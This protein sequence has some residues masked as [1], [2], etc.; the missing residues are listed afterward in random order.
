MKRDL[1]TFEKDEFDLL[2]IGGGIAGACIARDAAMRGLNVGLIE[3]N[4]FI[5]ATSAAPSKLIHGG[6]RYLKNFEL[7]LVRE[8]LAERRIWQRIAPHQVHPLPFLLPVSKS[9]KRPLSVGLS[10]YD[11]LSFDR[12]RLDDPA[13]HLAGHKWHRA[14]RAKEME[15]V[16]QHSEMAGAFTYLDCQMR[17]PE[18]LGLECLIDADAHGGKLANYVKA[19]SFVRDGDDIIGINA[20]DGLTGKNLLIRAKITLNAAGPWADQ[21]MGMAERSEPSRHLLRSKGIHLITKRLAHRHAVT[22][23]V[24]KE[25]GGGHMFLIPW[26]GHCIIG[27]TDTA[28]EGDPDALS[29]TDIEITDYLKFINA[30]VP[31]LDLTRDDVI[32]AYTGLRPLIAD[33]AEPDNPYNASR[34]AEVID[35][36]EDEGLKGLFSA[37]GGKWTT[38]RHVAEVAINMIG[39]R[40]QRALPACTTASTPLPGGDINR[41]EAFYPT[42]GTQHKELSH[43]S[44]M[45]IAQTYGSASDQIFDL[46]S[47][48]A[49]AA[50]TFCED[51]SEIAAQVTHAARH[52]MALTLEDAVFRRTGLGTLGDPGPGALKKAAHLMAQELSWDDAQQIEELRKVRR[53][54]YAEPDRQ[55]QLRVQ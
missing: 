35:H 9:D 18:R 39:R 16:L 36:E 14:D 32:H 49:S 1:A 28:Y 45:E 4:D 55:I 37:I 31:G 6:L 26:R 10:L 42:A 54:F 21:M 22:V 12:N 15:P 3:K 34:R 13:Q 40:L 33:A 19:T 24:P 11:L 2:I 50:E 8:S 23:T 44:R 17:S 48:D 52:E 20:Q 46:I 47:D 41:L 27:T 7:G 53:L 25:Q 5:S 51:R 43:A 38:S 30:A 29:V